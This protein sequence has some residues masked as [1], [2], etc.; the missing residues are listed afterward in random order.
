MDDQIKNHNQTM[1]STP[2][3]PT[4][5]DTNEPK[6]TP[7]EPKASADEPNTSPE[8]PKTKSD[9]VAQDLSD[10]R[11]AKPDEADEKPNR[12]QDAARGMRTV[13]GA[14]FSWIVF[15]IAV[16]LLLHN[17][18]FQAYH[19]VGV[20][21]VPNLHESDY[22][23][24]SKIGNTQAFLQRLTGKNV[25]YIPGR[26]QIIVFHFPKDP[27]RVFVKRVIG[28]PGDR[29]VIKAGQVTIYNADHPEGFNPDVKYEAKDTVTLH[30]TDETV[31]A[32]SVFVLGDNRT[33]NGSYDSRDWGEVP[34]SYIIG[35]AV[36]RLLPLDQVKTL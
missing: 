3:E 9:L 34:S 26:G 11:L 8:E 28:L 10:T 20:S 2:D 33:P 21:M 23:I 36:L 24:I 13:L 22:L 30:D 32:G 17:F 29:V 14:I 7:S 19:V 4:P 27:A 25:T 12:L 1:G 15:P 18:V 35:N 16:V 6:V 5:T 31:Q